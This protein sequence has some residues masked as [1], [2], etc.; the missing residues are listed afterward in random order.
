MSRYDAVLVLG[1][2]VRSGGSLPSWIVCRLQRAIERR[3]DGYII[4]LSAGTPY[5]PPP[6]DSEGFP[7]FESVAE[8]RYLMSAG[9]P[10]DK[11]LQE[12]SSYDTIGNAYFARTVHTDPGELSKLLVITSDFHI[13]RTQ[14]IFKW[15]FGLTPLRTEYRLEFEPVTDPALSPELLEKRAV[16]EASSLEATRL[17]I[18]TLA[19]L[20]EFHRWFFSKHRAYQAGNP[21]FGNT[22]INR[23][24]L[25]MY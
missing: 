14:A 3:G 23:Y 24:L 8:A 18:E 4:A 22:K 7:I 13:E 1:G 5:R 16:K 12:T 25:D 9:I 2:G 10:Q 11:I 17:Q 20:A 6:L 19:S 21:A 15:V